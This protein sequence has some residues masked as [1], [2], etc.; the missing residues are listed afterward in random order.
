MLGAAWSPYQYNI[1]TVNCPE[2]STD[3]VPTLHISATAVIIW[4]SN[5]PTEGKE[6]NELPSLAFAILLGR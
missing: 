3:A 1:S 6:N 2:R 5:I 4:I